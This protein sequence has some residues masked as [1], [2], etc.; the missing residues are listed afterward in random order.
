MEI[1][2][3]STK[4]ANMKAGAVNSL[5]VK[6]SEERKC[7]LQDHKVSEWLKSAPSTA[8]CIKKWHADLEASLTDP[9]GNPII[10]EGCIIEAAGEAI[11]ITKVGKR[12]FPECELLK[13]TGMPC[14]L[15]KGVAFGKPVQ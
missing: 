8:L 13:E 14:P 3:E 9:E 15:A 5:E 4:K 6:Y 2:K 7:S 12:C 1:N 11:E 10:S